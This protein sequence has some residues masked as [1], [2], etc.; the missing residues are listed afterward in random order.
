MAKGVENTRGMKNPQGNSEGY[1]RVGVRVQ[2]LL[3]LTYPYPW[4]GYAGVWEGMVVPFQSKKLPYSESSEIE[5]V[6][7]KTE[8]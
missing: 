3:P 6:I 5:L 2:E 7:L 1:V 4:K 8:T